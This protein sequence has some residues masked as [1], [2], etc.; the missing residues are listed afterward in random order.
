MTVW[1]ARIGILIPCVNVV[2]EQDFHRLL[3]DGVTAHAA[4]VGRSQLKSTLSAEHETVQRAV[5]AVRL[6]AHACVD[7]VVFGCTA[8]SVTRG[9]GGDLEIGA[10]IASA[11]G[12]PCVTTATA[13]VESLRAVGAR[14]IS[15]ATPYID[16]INSIEEAFLR[17][18]GFE[19]PAVKGLG[20]VES[21]QI[22]RVSPESIYRF[23]RSVFRPGSDAL[24]ISCTNFRAAEIAPVLEQDLGVPVITSNTASLWAALRRLGIND[25][26]PGGG[27]LFNGGERVMR[28]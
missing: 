26:V 19:V 27:V 3:P 12:M 24:F 14:S 6:L 10:E 8:A 16:E 18:S 5:E 15:V 22:P 17:D 4:R 1:R 20:I 9:P 13:V 11:G 7:I 25:A 23:A 21:V 2:M 28:K